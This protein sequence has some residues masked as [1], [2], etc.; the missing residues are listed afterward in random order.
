[1]SYTAHYGGIVMVCTWSSRLRGAFVCG[2]PLSVFVPAQIDLYSRVI[3][4]QKFRIC[5]SLCFIAWII[6]LMGGQ[7]SVCPHSG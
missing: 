2:D 3:W 4:I 5:F 6:A 7:F 1:M